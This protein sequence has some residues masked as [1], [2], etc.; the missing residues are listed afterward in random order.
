[1]VSKQAVPPNKVRE[2]R[3]EKGLTMEELGE[4]AGA[5]LGKAVHFTTIAK[6]ERSQRGLSGELLHAIAQALD[7]APAE[8]V[9][10]VPKTIPVRMVPIVG[11]IAAG[12]WRE[13]VEDAQGYI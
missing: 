9:A 1:M 2:V 5:V 13:A 4:R 12:N 7:V 11:K 10:S 8:L 3:K 6:I